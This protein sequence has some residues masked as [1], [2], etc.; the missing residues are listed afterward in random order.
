MSTAAVLPLIERVGAKKAA[1]TELDADS[2]ATPTKLREVAQALERSRS[3]EA[4]TILIAQF[5]KHARHLEAHEHSSQIAVTED[6]VTVTE[7]RPMGSVLLVP[8]PSCGGSTIGTHI[9]AALAA[10]NQISLATF[11]PVD[12]IT[13]LFHETLTNVLTSRLFAVLSPGTGWETPGRQS[14]MVVTSDGAFAND[15]P[16]WRH[17]NVASNSTEI[18]DLIRFYGRS[19]SIHMPFHTSP[20]RGF[21]S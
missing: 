15:Q 12:R 1:A 13:N 17:H 4:F 14:I 6:M 10:G 18:A 19:S 20:Y 7:S 3:R 5:E 11:E 8:V 2:V 16:W 9:A 21:T